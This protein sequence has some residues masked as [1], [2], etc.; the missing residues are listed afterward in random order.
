MVEIYAI[1]LSTYCIIFILTIPSIYITHSILHLFHRIAEWVEEMKLSMD[2]VW[3][4]IRSKYRYVFG[5]GNLSIFAYAPIQFD[6]EYKVS[7]TFEVTLKIECIP[8][9]THS[10]QHLCTHID[11]HVYTEI[12]DFICDSIINHEYETLVERRYTHTLSEHTS[13]SIRTWEHTKTLI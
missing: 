9:C 8:I 12:I 3:N 7:V 13:F 1:L 5:I 10:I 2:V 11:R 6:F 4:A